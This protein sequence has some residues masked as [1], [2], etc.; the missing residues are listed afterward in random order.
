MQ[1]QR[2]RAP[3]RF[4]AHRLP[5][6]LPPGVLPEHSTFKLVA[7][8]ARRLRALMLSQP[9]GPECGGDCWVP[10]ESAFGLLRR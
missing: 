9:P 6:P 10:A 1:A 7:E 8:H 5:A 2:R 3:G 4:L